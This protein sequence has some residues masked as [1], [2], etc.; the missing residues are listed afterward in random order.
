MAVVVGLGVF[1]AAMLWLDVPVGRWAVGQGKWPKAMEQVAR[2][3]GHFVFTLAIGAALVLWR[4]RWWP[5]VA[6]LAA[7][8]GSGMVVWL[9]KWLAGR[10]RPKVGLDRAFVF[11]PMGGGLAGLVWQKP[12][13]SFPS[14]DVALA[15]ATA[16]CLG[17]W[18]G[19]WAWAFYAWAVVVAVQRV[20]SASHYVSEVVLAAVL[21]VV[22]AKTAIGL[23]GALDRR[24]KT[25][26][27][28]T[29]SAEP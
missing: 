28:G 27:L 19:R 11:E 4:R 21:G 5:A 9:M 29:E 14:G 2:L 18:L 8:A 16:V 15:V 3:P 25:S 6:L 20:S 7:G 13:L 24:G 12:N 22:L 1:G 26:E 10:Q 17:H 23:A